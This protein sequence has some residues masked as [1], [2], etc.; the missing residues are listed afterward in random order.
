MKLSLGS[1]LKKNTFDVTVFYKNNFNT[2]HMTTSDKIIKLR[3]EVT[4]SLSLDN[5]ELYAGKFHINEFYYNLPI[6]KIVSM[7]GFNVF[8]LITNEEQQYH[9]I[10]NKNSQDLLKETD[11]C[12]NNEGIVKFFELSKINEDFIKIKEN[13]D[14]IYLRICKANESLIT[15]NTN[16]NQDYTERPEELQ[17]YLEELFLQILQLKIMEKEAL[18]EIKENKRLVALIH[19]NDIKTIKKNK[20]IS[21]KTHQSIL[22]LTIF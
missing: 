13:L 16:Q 4:K 20:E 1:I 22:I 17:R 3:E 11:E 18:E 10:E 9:I 14:I 15:V 2:F 6:V 21:V 5:F 12:M 19:S 7:F 8:T